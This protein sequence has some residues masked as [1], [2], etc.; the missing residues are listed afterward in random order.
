MSTHN[1][2]NTIKDC[3][4]CH[5]QIAI[6]IASYQLIIR[7]VVFFSWM[8]DI[9][10]TYLIFSL[11]GLLVGESSHSTWLSSRE[12]STPTCDNGMPHII[13]C[14]LY[15]L[16]LSIWFEQTL[17]SFSLLN[18]LLSKYPFNIFPLVSC[19]FLV[20][21]HLLW[22]VPGLVDWRIIDFT[23]ILHDFASLGAMV[24]ICITG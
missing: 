2:T 13:F 12:L 5:S 16:N 15:P 18:V 6:F 24:S 8:Q 20:L 17:Y 19:D 10:N 11:R 14:G 4:H 9:I 3:I 21:L 22:S 23:I 1:I 7:L